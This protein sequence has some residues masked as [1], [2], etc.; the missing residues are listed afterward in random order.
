MPNG[1]HPRFAKRLSPATLQAMVFMWHPDAIDTFDAHL[2]E[3]SQFADVTNQSITG[4]DD[5]WIT[6]ITV[7]HWR[8]QDE[9]ESKIRRIE[10][11]VDE[12]ERAE[13]EATL[14][15]KQALLEKE[16]RE[17]HHHGGRG[18]AGAVAT[19]T[20]T[21]T[22]T[23]SKIKDDFPPR[24]VA[25]ERHGKIHELRL[26]LAITG[27]GRGRNWTCSVVCELFD[28]AAALAHAREAAEILQMFIHQQDTGRALVFLLLLGYICEALAGECEG[29]IQE[30]DGIM[31]RN[32][33]AW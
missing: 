22:T 6:S 10:D 20:T 23:K 32:V 15:A 2:G 8:L 9:L 19:A 26:S 24:S 3:L 17:K 33:S 13:R 29:F 31:T 21:T 28:E 30:L 7:S 14:E 27:D 18:T 4:G 12:S 16:K 5:T 1:Y 11:A 25:E